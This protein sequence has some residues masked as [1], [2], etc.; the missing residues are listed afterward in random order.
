MVVTKEQIAAVKK[1]YAQSPKGIK[2]GRIS[3]WKFRGMIS[4]D[5]DKTYD[6]YIN[7]LNCQ[8]PECNV[9]FTTSKIIST[10]TKCLD[11][12]HNILDSPNIRNVLCNRCNL[13]DRSTNT[14]GTPNV[15]RYRGGWQY[16]RFYNGKI[17]QKW[18]KIKEEACSYKIEFELIMRDS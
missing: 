16:R 1:K 5:W 18:F 3:R 13:N 12:D 2:S 14:S 10:T 6:W 7:T 4:D 8:N 15:N 17:H 11:H 9:I